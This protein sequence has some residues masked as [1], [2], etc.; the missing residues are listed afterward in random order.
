MKERWLSSQTGL[1]DA[2]AQRDHLNTIRKE[3]LAELAALKARW[4]E[5]QS[6]RDELVV[7]LE[8]ELA[9]LKRLPRE[10][11]PGEIDHEMLR[12]HNEA[13]LA[14]LAELKAESEQRLQMFY[15]KDDELAALNGALTSASNAMAERDQLASI[16]GNSM[17]WRRIQELEA[18]LAAL[19][20]RECWTCRWHHDCEIEELILRREVGDTWSC[21]EWA[22]REEK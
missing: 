2:L 6:K 9:E 5:H 14:E 7:A 13:L 8:A 20:A 12:Q 11:L 18:E 10:P 22:A 16:L 15:R 21:S 4:V 1:S 3:L 17:P 19:K